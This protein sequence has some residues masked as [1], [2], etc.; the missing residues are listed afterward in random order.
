MRLPLMI[1]GS[2]C[3]LLLS[4]CTPYPGLYYAE[5]THFGLQV[6]VNPKENKPLDV[7]MGY[8]RGN[9]AVVPRTKKGHDGDAASVLSKTDLCVKFL[10][11]S[12][13]RNV[14]ASGKAA[15]TITGETTKATSG[16]TD[17]TAAKRLEALFGL[18]D[19]NKSTGAAKSTGCE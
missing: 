11:S 10:E 4:A 6:K 9:F 1:K 17:N 2:P 19:K 13:I 3:I 16:A 8:D 5:H 14:Y 7:N 18:E 15:N 12:V